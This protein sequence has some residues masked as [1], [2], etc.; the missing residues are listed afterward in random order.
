[1]TLL[2]LKARVVG[3]ELTLTND[4]IRL[5]PRDQFAQFEP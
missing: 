4:M 1:M 2:V 5:S 3:G